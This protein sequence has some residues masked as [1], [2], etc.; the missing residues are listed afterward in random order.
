MILNQNKKL[1]LLLA[2]CLNLSLLT[3]IWPEIARAESEPPKIIIHQNLGQLSSIIA[4]D[5]E[6]ETSE[7]D[8]LV[9]DAQTSCDSNIFV[10]RQATIYNEGDEIDTT[11]NTGKIYCFRVTSQSGD[12][13]Y[14][15]Y[16]ASSPIGLVKINV[17]ETLKNDDQDLGY[18]SAQVEALEPESF[19]YILI[20]TEDDSACNL[21]RLTEAH[22][23]PQSDILLYNTT[24][25]LATYEAD[26]KI[27]I[28][29]KYHNLAVCF[30][31]SKG[32]EF[33]YQSSAKIFFETIKIFE[34][35]VKIKNQ[36]NQ[37]HIKATDTYS[38]DQQPTSWKYKFIDNAQECNQESLA[39]DTRAYIEGETVKLNATDQVYNGLKACFSSSQEID[40][41]TQSLYAQTDVIQINSA[42][43]DQINTDTEKIKDKSDSNLTNILLVSLGCILIAGLAFLSYF[44]FKKKQTKNDD[45][46]S[47]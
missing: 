16:Q 8:Y 37:Y 47:Q 34:T 17:T 3:L 30:V 22:R 32:S 43:L 45:K 23:Q 42:N 7:R 14:S 26:Q 25:K 15:I 35:T 46:D 2:V 39:E 33:F 18:I 19:H 40:E 38:N 4:Y 44:L 31:A 27:M 11:T 12:N 20:N 1:I 10:E 36:L 5:N 21:Y 29:A 13:I 41:Q 28:E 24:G 9:I 6:P